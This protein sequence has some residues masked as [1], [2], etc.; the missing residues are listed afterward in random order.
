MSRVL[1]SLDNLM[2][3][4]PGIEIS[5]AQRK[6]SLEIEEIVLVDLRLGSLVAGRL[7][8]PDV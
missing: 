8:G 1:V 6:T 3:V 5:V 4:S 7:L 2:V